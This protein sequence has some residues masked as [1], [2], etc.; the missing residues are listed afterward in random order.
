MVLSCKVS[1]Y[2][3]FSLIILLVFLYP[4]SSSG[5]A[6]GRIMSAQAKTNI[7]AHRSLQAKI[8]GQLQA[9][10]QIRADFLE[11]GWYAVFAVDERERLE[12]KAR[13]YVYASRLEAVPPPA[14]SIITDRIGGKVSDKPAVAP[15]S[16]E[17]PTLILKNI[18]VK[19]EPAGHE[20]VFMDFNR[21]VSPEIS[22]IDGNNPRI[23]IDIKNVLSIRQGLTR[24]KARGKLILQLRSALDRSSHRLRI[25]VDLAPS[26]NY[27]VEPVYYKAEKIY[28]I[29]INEK[30]ADTKD[31]KQKSAP[32]R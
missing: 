12:S 4:A 32:P 3:I 26:R 11:D 29:D 8:T 6:W 5:Q 20:K 28:V 30:I 15:A 2:L 27:E 31:K 19:S 17:A 24:I 14:A 13:G 7:R 21:D 18:T 22:S 1:N 10:D 16:R 9:G 25:V 23:V